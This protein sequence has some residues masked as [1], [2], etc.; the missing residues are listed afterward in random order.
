[1][2]EIGCKLAEQWSWDGRGGLEAWFWSDVHDTA[3]VPRADEQ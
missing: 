3:T 2:K 1:M